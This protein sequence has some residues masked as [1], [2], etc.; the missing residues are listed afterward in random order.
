LTVLVSSSMLAAVSSR[1]LAA[2]SVRLDRSWLP[3]AISCDATLMLSVALRT[4][5]TV[6]TSEAFILPRALSRSPS[7]S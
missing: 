5:L 6:L 1:L 2:C 7:S 4:W 3:A